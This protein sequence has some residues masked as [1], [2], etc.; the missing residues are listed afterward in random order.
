M[1]NKKLWQ[2]STYDKNVNRKALEDI[3]RLTSLDCFQDMCTKLLVERR[4]KDRF[5]LYLKIYDGT[6]QITLQLIKNGEKECVEE[7]INYIK[8]EYQIEEVEAVKDDEG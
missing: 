7:L 8:D 1:W 4:K 2:I 6:V 3:E 5:N